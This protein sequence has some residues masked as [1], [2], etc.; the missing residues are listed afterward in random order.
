[1]MITSKFTRSK[2]KQAAVFLFSIFQ[3]WSTSWIQRSMFKNTIA[4]PPFNSTYCIIQRCVA[5]IIVVFWISTISLIISQHT[6]TTEP[7]WLL[8]KRQCPFEHW[9][10][11]TALPLALSRQLLPWWRKK[12][13]KCLPTILKIPFVPNQTDG[14]S[15]VEDPAAFPM[16]HPP[17]WQIQP[18]DSRHDLPCRGVTSLIQYWEFPVYATVW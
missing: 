17:F 13:K 18:I 12:K 3:W 5:S 15:W 8:P 4:P 10:D 9:R 6:L 7:S 14:G 2:Q 16:P 11:P 1:M